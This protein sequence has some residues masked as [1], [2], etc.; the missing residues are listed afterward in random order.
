MSDFKN[1]KLNTNNPRTISKVKYEKLLKSIETFTKMLELRPIIYDEND[2]IWGGNMRYT[3]LMQ[4]HN[5]GKVELKP[6]Y[7]KKIEGYTEEEKREFAIRD[8]VELG[9]WDMDMLANEWGDLP[10]DDWGAGVG[11]LW[12][13]VLD[14]VEGVEV[15]ENRLFVLTV[16]A[17]EAPRLKERMAFYCESIEDYLRVKEYFVS[18]GSALDI[19]K[20]LALI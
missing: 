9:D 2:V 15:D 4:L 10:L 1:L 11:D 7:F 3:A 6:E 20:L 12:S 16:E 18:S 8:N 14:T 19:K 13:E 5:D 17:P